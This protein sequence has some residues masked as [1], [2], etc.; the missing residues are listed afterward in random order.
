VKIIRDVSFKVALQNILI[1]IKKDKNSPIVKFKKELNSYIQLLKY[2]PKMGIVYKLQY[3]K[4]VYNGYS[5][6]Y[7]IENDTIYILD[8]FKWQ[9]K[10]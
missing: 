10:N 8:I 4:L 3:R 2:N 5:I 9:N 7:K 6:V 1:Y